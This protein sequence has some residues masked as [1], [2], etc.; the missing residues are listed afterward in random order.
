MSDQSDKRKTIVGLYPSR[1][2]CYDA[3]SSPDRERLKIQN[4]M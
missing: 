1:N 2:Y 4:F 3:M